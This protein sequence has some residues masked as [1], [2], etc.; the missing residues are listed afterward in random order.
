MDIEFTWDRSKAKGNLEK[1]GVT[2]KKAKQV[3]FDPYLIVVEDC[4][5]DGEM[6]Y[7]ALGYAGSDLLLV[8]HVDRSKKDQI[9]RAHV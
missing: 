1:H 5:G 8:V 2:F 3:F 6:S 4:E 9:G 7:H